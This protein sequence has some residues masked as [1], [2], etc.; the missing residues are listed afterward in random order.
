M[1]TG[2]R[3]S[4]QDSLVGHNEISGLSAG[5]QVSATISFREPRMTGAA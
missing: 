5:I 4:T 2:A 1:M 3:M